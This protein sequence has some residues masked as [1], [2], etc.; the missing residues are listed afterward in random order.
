MLIATIGIKYFIPSF[1]SPLL[2]NPRTNEAKI[3]VDIMNT[4][5]KHSTNRGEIL[6]FESVKG[7]WY[8]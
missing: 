7:S 5:E 8:I 6:T 4:R 2:T 3:S 1:S